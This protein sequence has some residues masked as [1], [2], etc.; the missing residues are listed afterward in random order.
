[1]ELTAGPTTRSRAVTGLILGYFAVFAY[2]TITNDPLAATVT[3][4]GFGIV[5][6]A[7]GAMLYGQRS[8]PWAALTAAAGCLVAGGVLTVGAVLTQSAVVDGLSS[9]LVLL[10]L[11]CYGYAIW[12][13]N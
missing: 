10:G 11:G 3:Q 12:R 7:V 8:A 13:A 4:L 6:I 5:A 2:A 1:M 9:L